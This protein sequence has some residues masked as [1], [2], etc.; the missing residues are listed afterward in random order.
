MSLTNGKSMTWDFFV[1][2]TC[3]VSWFI[4]EVVK[5]QPCNEPRVRVSVDTR[6]F[7]IHL[8]FAG[9]STQGSAWVKTC[10][11]RFVPEFV[12]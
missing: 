4:N 2:S 7:L 9:M 12:N 5:S 3:F 10:F 6:L 8:W 11:V 1:S